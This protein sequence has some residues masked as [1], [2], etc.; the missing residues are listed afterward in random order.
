MPTLNRKLYIFDLGGVL[1][2]DFDTIGRMAGVLSLP[3]D[4]LEADYREY[5]KP[6]MEGFMSTDD[7]YR[8][9][10]I[11]FGVKVNEDL[12]STCFMPF[13]VN[14]LMLS[15]A[16]GIRTSGGRCVIGSNTFAPHW[17][18]LFSSGVGAHFDAHY[19]SHL[20]HM[21]K[22]DGEFWRYILVHEGF[23]PEDAVFID[24]RTENVMG[25]ASVGIDAFHYTSD[26]ALK[27]RF[28]C[29]LE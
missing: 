3:K 29:F 28:G 18:Y 24:D 12:F 26:E 16:D 17:P 11:H 5:D 27:E 13:N 7:Y 21:S 4:V 22:P 9:L 14:T 8:H 6:L 1:L 2:M 15:L 19:A 10:E 20:M 25:A 23:S